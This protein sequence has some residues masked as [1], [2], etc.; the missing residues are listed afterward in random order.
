M[1][2]Y[3]WQYIF[4]FFIIR[5]LVLLAFNANVVGK[6]IGNGLNNVYKK[7]VDSKFF[8]KGLFLC[9]L[10]DCQRCL[11]NHLR[12]NKDSNR[13]EW[14][15]F[16]VKHSKVVCGMCQCKILSYSGHLIKF[17]FVLKGNFCGTWALSS[18]LA[19]CS[20]GSSLRHS[21]LWR[22]TW[23]STQVHYV[24][25]GGNAWWNYWWNPPNTLQNSNN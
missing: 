3:C 19:A 23:R 5:S 16:A 15:Y 12:L 11:K 17:Q 18:A 10:F 2:S 8:N 24:S 13:G 25:P 20:Y 21:F 22:T 4:T 9:W 7:K 1:I 14:S 6:N